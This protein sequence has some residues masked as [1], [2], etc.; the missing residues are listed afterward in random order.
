VHTRASE[1]PILDIPVGFS[2]RGHGQAP[3]GNAPPHPPVSLEQLLATQNDMMS[4]LMENETRCGAKRQQPRHQDWDSSY[5]VF[6]ATHPSVFADAIDP[7]DVDNWLH[8][9]ESK[10][11]LLHCMEFQKTLYATQQLRGSAG[12]WLASYITSLPTDH[13]I[14][15]GEFRTTFCAHHLSMGVLRSKWKEFLD[16]EQGNHTMF[17]YTR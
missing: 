6:L 3:R 10:F 9:M 2:G 14:P 5:S 7:L 8:M 16:L 17:Y 15:W 4:I 12:A 1:D 13:H 11:G